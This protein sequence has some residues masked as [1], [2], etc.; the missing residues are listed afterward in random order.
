VLSGSKSLLLTPAGLSPVGGKDGLLP[1][2]PPKWIDSGRLLERPVFAAL[3]PVFNHWCKRVSDAPDNVPA[4][5]CICGRNGDGKSALLLQL[6]AA[7][8]QGNTV[9]ALRLWEAGDDPRQ[10]ETPP[11][12]DVTWH[13]VD[14]LP[15]LVHGATGESWLRRLREQPRVSI[16]TTASPAALDWFAKKY[17]KRF[18]LTVWQLP[19]LAA[20]EAMA[21]AAD[22]G[23]VDGKSL[24][25]D[26]MT[27]ETF[28]FAVKNGS[29]LAERLDSL[30]V[31]F[32]PVVVAANLLG[33][34][35]PGSLLK[36][37]LQTLAQQLAGTDL[38]PV[39]ISPDGL[40][41]V[42]PG[43]AQPLFDR[44]FP[45]VATRLEKV[46][47][48][49][50]RLLEIWLQEKNA[51]AASWFLRRLLHSEHL[52]RLLPPNSRP[53]DLRFLRKNLFR[54]LYRQHRAGCGDLPSVWLLSAWMEIGQTFRLRP[55]VMED[56]AGLL[57]GAPEN[58]SPALATDI[59]LHSEYRKNPLATRLREGVAN[60]FMGA[61]ADAIDTGAALTRL[62]TETNQND[63]ALPVLQRWLEKHPFHSR[64]R[65]AFGALLAKP[66]RH[67][68]V[69]KWALECLGWHWRGRAAG[70]PLATLLQHNPASEPVCKHARH[71]LAQNAGCPE[72]GAVLTGLLGGGENEPREV[73]A[74]LLW[75]TQFPVHPVAG[76]L[77]NILLNHHAGQ[78]DVRQVAL[79]WI[80]ACPQHPQATAMLLAIARKEKSNPAFVAAVQGWLAGRTTHEQTPVLLETLASSTDEAIRR[81]LAQW[82]EENGQHPAAARLL[83]A[84]L[85]AGK[86][87]PDW[88][89]RAETFLRSGH[90][91]ALRVLRV[92]LATS[93]SDPVLK[94]A[95]EWLV[96]APPP[97]QRQ[98]SRSLGKL[99]GRQPE[100]AAVLR[101]GLP[102]QPL[103]ADEFFSSLRETLWDMPAVQL[104]NWMKRGFGKLTEA[105][106]QWMFQRLLEQATPLPAPF[107]IALAEWLLRNTKKPAYQQMVQILRQH[108]RQGRY[109]HSAS[110]L[111]LNLLADVMG[112]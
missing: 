89:Q 36:A 6:A 58:I 5:F 3:W 66:Y 109:F 53:L 39:Q 90:P 95:W 46:A 19:P 21:L 49:F 56:A 34:A 71:W 72:A 96:Q 26:H 91:D 27:L 98:L 99:A 7:L 111:P 43:L 25:H 105:D 83:A 69:Q 85:C 86:I 29:S 40:R 77:W 81:L 67:G 37:E 74:A 60:F 31:E 100:R 104:D 30:A 88:M 102:D 18:A 61:K 17:P 64:F 62:Y 106:Q 51:A 1:G 75:V 35:V 16:V 8:L 28:L 59:W 52:P 42:T 2:L 24:W 101:H 97:V 13:F 108:P 10:F 84:V 57:E 103:L 63:P 78:A 82:L 112:R 65:D 12:N 4:V 22:A 76:D 32:L 70:K 55:D 94:L 92:L 73:R 107:S 80:K 14:R 41:L 68:Q 54:E 33:L 11:A 45:D 20:T 9:P 15:E 47:A 110:M 48:G 93:A 38:L 44:W 87:S 23:H 50:A 79:E